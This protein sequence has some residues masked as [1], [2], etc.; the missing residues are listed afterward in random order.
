MELFGGEGMGKFLSGNIVFVRIQSN[1][2][3]SFKIVQW[4]WTLRA[5]K[6]ES[7]EQSQPGEGLLWE[8]IEQLESKSVF[9]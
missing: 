4:W 5:L 3:A 2:D 8:I 6:K 7:D 9:K 1:I